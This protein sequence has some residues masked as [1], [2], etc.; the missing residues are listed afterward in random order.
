MFHTLVVDSK[1]RRFS[2]HHPKFSNQSFDP[3]KNYFNIAKQ[4]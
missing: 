4:I 3:N 2:T 1:T